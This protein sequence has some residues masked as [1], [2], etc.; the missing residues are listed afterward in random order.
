MLPFLVQRLDGREVYDYREL[1]ISLGEE[2]GLVEV[3]LGGT[4][5]L[6]KVT[7]QV[8]QPKPHR[9]TDGQLF[10]NVELS[11]MASPAFE[12][13]RYKLALSVACICFF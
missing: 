4:R 12:V 1:A 8:V 13:G 3:R 9:P 7:G 10:F 5:V 11:P 6:A 2:P